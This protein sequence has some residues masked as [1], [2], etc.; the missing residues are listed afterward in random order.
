METPTAD[1]RDGFAEFNRLNR[2]LSGLDERGLVLSLSAFAED[3]LGELLRVF[4]REHVA[5]A[6]LLDGFNAPLGTFSSR[7]KAAVAL[8]L[9]TPEQFSDLENLRKIRNK[10]SH[11]WE[12]MSFEDQSIK[13]RI[14]SLSYSPIDDQFPATPF[15]KIKSSLAAILIEIRVTIA[16]IE[17]ENLQTK[18]IG[19]RLF[20]GLS[21]NSDGEKLA[22]A[23]ELLD[24]IRRKFRSAEPKEQEFLLMIKQRLLLRV[25]LAAVGASGEDSIEFAQLLAI[26]ESE[27]WLKTG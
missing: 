20:S 4:M 16:K 8:G 12:D 18:K 24:S 2:R 17:K 22:S 21:G 10:F 15:D 19:S 5:A 25:I 11:T 27:D 3:S 1:D 9:I 7:I 23:N 14:E 6:G 26:L 13:D